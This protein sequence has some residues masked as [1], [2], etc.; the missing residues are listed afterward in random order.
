[1]IALAWTRSERSLAGE[2]VAAVALPGASAPVAVAS[3]LAWPRAAALWAAWTVRYACSVVAVH[4][5]IARHRRAATAADRGLAAA[6]VGITVAVAAL[7]TAAA[8]A[9]PAVPLAGASAML[10]IAPPRATRLRA[11]GV[12]LVIASIASG[13]LAIAAA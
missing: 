6:A 10:L 8:I 12:A 9:A 11:V 2:L 1:V 4:R 5:V 13:A 7:A 3:G